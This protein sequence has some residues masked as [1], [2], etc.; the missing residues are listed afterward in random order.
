MDLLEP[1]ACACMYRILNKCRSAFLGKDTGTGQ[2]TNYAGTSTAPKFGFTSIG[3]LLAGSEQQPFLV[4]PT[5]LGDPKSSLG[6]VLQLAV[7]TQAFFRDD[8]ARLWENG[9]PKSKS[10][11]P[12]S[13][14]GFRL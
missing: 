13:P 11:P 6:P 12:G 8:R 10:S 2:T 14:A 7:L 9:L 4:E 3:V 1:L 5:K